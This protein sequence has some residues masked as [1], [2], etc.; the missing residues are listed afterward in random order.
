VIL[1]EEWNAARGF[2]DLYRVACDN[3][4]IARELLKLQR[5]D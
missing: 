3:V 4:A 5:A 1:E 2:G